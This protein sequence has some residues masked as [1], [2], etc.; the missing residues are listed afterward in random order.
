MAKL[1]DLIIGNPDVKTFDEL[2]RLVANAGESG[3]MFLEFDLKP[4]YRDTPR[5]WEWRLEAAF[6]RG[7]RYD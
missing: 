4:D 1:S 3:Q 7:T 5:K 2:E 6:T